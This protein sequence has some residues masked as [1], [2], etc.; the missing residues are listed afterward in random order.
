MSSEFGSANPYV[1]PSYADY[2]PRQEREKAPGSVLAPAMALILV[3][4]I[5]LLFSGFNFAMSFGEAKVD[6]TAPPMV[7]EI[8]RGT[9]GPL[10]TGI[11]GTFCLLNLFIIFSAVQMMR[12]QNWGMAVAGSVLAMVNL[13]SCCC[14]VGIPVGIWSLSALMS[15]DTI[16]M[17]SAAAQEQ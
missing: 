6:P 17:F 16:S 2:A 13:G 4:A 3:A 11:Q 14:V 9:A 7:Q 5:G 12:L 8:Q 1:S 10:A 15:P